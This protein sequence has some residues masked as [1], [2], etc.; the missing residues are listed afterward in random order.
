MPIT[1]SFLPA[2]GNVLR[3]TPG[4][5]DAPLPSPGAVPD[6]L[7]QRRSVRLAGYDYGQ[8]GW[9]FVTIMTHDRAPLFGHITPEARLVPTPL[10]E[11]ICQSWQDLTTRYDHLHADC[12]VLMPNHVHLLLGLLPTTD[13]MP[14]KSLGQ[15]VGAFKATCTRS[16]RPWLPPGRLWQRN[17]HEHIIRT[18]L[19]LENHRQ[20]V[21]HNPQR[22]VE[23]A[24]IGLS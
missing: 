3:P 7:P 4:A 16:G 23:K 24:Q 13:R 11:A 10:G 21:R 12:W 20:Y 19:D 15:L 6:A 14:A 17:Y 2:P 1:P 8:A 18:A 5:C 9:Y 22:W